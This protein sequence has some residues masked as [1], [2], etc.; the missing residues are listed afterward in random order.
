MIVKLDVKRSNV[1]FISTQCLTHLK[2][3]KLFTSS[4][5]REKKLLSLSLS[6]K[7]R[8][9]QIKKH[10]AVCQWLA[11][12]TSNCSTSN[13]YKRDQGCNPPG[14]SYPQRRWVPHTITVT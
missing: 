5:S 8:K 4:K 14:T 7:D 11:V 2:P 3:S 9:E 13:P 1:P 10:V 12:G 6:A